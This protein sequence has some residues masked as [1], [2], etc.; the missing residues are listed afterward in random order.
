[1]T[2]QTDVLSTHLN[3]SG[4]I[5]AG[6]SRLRGMTLVG[7]ATVGTVQ[8]RDGGA[9]G[10]ILCEIDVP[11]NT[12]VNTFYVLVPGQGVR[13]LTSIYAAFTGGVSAMTAFYG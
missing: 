8:F 7:G 4:V 2:M 1:M 3:A 9:S 6:P 13:F 12:N 5:S 11:A 10:S